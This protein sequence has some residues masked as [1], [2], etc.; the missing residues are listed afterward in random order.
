MASAAVAERPS[1]GF[2]ILKRSR[3]LEQRSH[4]VPCVGR[5]S[6]SVLLK[7]DAD[8]F[9]LREHSSNKSSDSLIASD[10][11]YDLRTADPAQTMHAILNGA[12]EWQDG[13]PSKQE[14]LRS[15]M[16]LTLLSQTAKNTAVYI[17]V[18]R[19][20]ERDTPELL[21]H[22]LVYK[23]EAYMR[24][25]IASDLDTTRKTQLWT[26]SY[27][28]VPTKHRGSGLAKILLLQLQQHMRD[29]GVSL[30]VL[31]SDIGS[32]FY[33]KLQWHQ[34]QGHEWRY[35]TEPKSIKISHLPAFIYKLIRQSNLD[36]HAAPISLTSLGYI[37]QQEQIRFQQDLSRAPSESAFAIVPTIAHAEWD[38]LDMV[39][40]YA[41]K[42]SVSMQEAAASVFPGILLRSQTSSKDSYVLWNI[43]VVASVLL[44]TRIQLEDSRCLEFIVKRVI[45]S[46]AQAYGIKEI[47][48]WHQSIPDVLLPLAEQ[49]LSTAGYQASPID[50][51]VPCLYYGPNTV[52]A[53]VPLWMHN[54]PCFWL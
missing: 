11:P 41:G 7:E 8:R 38:Y 21:A 19:G 47:V 51:R 27:V 6:E 24:T 4:Y 16:Q 22:C 25:R 36:Y 39:C 34:A 12:E 31:Y 35:K 14:Y 26:I 18:P 5:D 52:N 29:L 2:P 40:K 46:V 10:S 54:E 15:M 37:V 44:V 45:P 32:S 3:L 42:Y 23:R 17:L 9:I 13:Y 50:S 30:S 48:L 33:S 20:A 28:F 49:I 1:P 43:D 53:T